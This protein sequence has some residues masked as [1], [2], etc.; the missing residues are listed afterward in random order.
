VY[1]L[2]LH[3]VWCPKYRRAVLVGDVASRLR[4]LIEAKAVEHGWRS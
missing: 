2:G 4:E 3:V 1:D